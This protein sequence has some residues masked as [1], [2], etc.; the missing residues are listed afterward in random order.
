MLFKKK[1][2]EDIENGVD[3]LESLKEET[4]M[5]DKIGFFKKVGGKIDGFFNSKGGKIVTVLTIVTAAGVAAYKVF[6]EDGSEAII[7]AGDDGYEE[8]N[9]ISRDEN[10]EVDDEPEEEMTEET[11]EN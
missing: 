7:E 3:L 4:E 2:Q 9:T 5:K 11:P 6:F 8:L 10:D 1:K